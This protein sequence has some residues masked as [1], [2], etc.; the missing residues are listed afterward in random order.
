MLQRLL[1]DNR[2]YSAEFGRRMSN[3]LSMAALAL[4]W[5]GASDSRVSDFAA[6]Y[7]SRV[8]LE[9]LRPPA[10][11]LT[12]DRWRE[13][14]GDPSIE[15]SAIAYFA[16]VLAES[17]R[18]ATLKAHLP[19]LMRGVGA[20]AFHALIRTAYALEADDDEELAAALSYWTMSW[21]D[22]GVAT[23]DGEAVNPLKIFDLFGSAFRPTAKLES[24]AIFRRMQAVAA[25]DSFVSVSV[26][27]SPSKAGL[28]D[29]AGAAVTLFAAT[30]DFTALHAVTG[31]HALR[32][33]LPWVDDHQ[34]ALAYHWR[35]LL[36]AYGSMGA[37]QLPSDGEIARLRRCATP[38]DWTDL[39]AVALASNDDHLIKS[40]YSAWRENAVYRDP[41]YALAA[42]RYAGIVVA[43]DC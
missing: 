23:L 3:H 8:Q 4:S 6:N 12:M 43:E 19:D 30:G 36:A 16:D 2:G 13:Y 28:A 11:R 25:H 1:A 18:A 17:G 10:M 41:L 33:V 20:A 14:L 31:T 26:R 37:P 7:R 27:Y 22:L 42:A 21:L 9:P 24:G 39:R 35:A 5:M 40:I 29:L 34:T 15:G 38:P 32:L